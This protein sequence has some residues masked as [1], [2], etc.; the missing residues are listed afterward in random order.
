M[1][2]IRQKEIENSKKQIEVNKN[3][4]EK[5]KEKLKGFGPTGGGAE[6][7]Q[8]I[9]WESKYQAQLD[10]K[11]RLEKSIKQLEKQNSLQGNQI[12]KAQNSEEQ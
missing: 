4:I 3:V 6:E 2:R 8:A 7:A 5:L 11:A 12:E 9:S 1:L 10:L